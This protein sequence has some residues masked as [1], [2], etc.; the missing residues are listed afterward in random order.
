MYPHSILTMNGATNPNPVQLSGIRS[1]NTENILPAR[2][3]LFSV[4]A[5]S[6]KP[7]EKQENEQNY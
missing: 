7:E 3:F 1:Y 6:S 5:A 2:R 4:A